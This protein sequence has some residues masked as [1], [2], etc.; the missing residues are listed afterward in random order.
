MLH[1]IKKILKTKIRIRKEAKDKEFIGYHLEDLEFTT[2]T[3][4]QILS[5]MNP[6]TII[7][8]CDELKER[9]EKILNSAE[10]IKK[11]RDVVSQRFIN[12]MKYGVD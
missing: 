11:I 1:K 5:R 8:D 2:E 7:T 3:A 9:A 4:F 12:Y 10:F 6:I